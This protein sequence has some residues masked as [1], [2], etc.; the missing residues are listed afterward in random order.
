MISTKYSAPAT[1]Q[2]QSSVSSGTPP[3]T[4]LWTFPDGSTSA[5]ESPTFIFSIAGSFS[6]TFTVTDS[7]GNTST[8][9]IPITIFSSGLSVLLAV[10]PT[11]NILMYHFNTSVSGGTAPYVYLLEFGDGKHTADAT[12]NHVYAKAGTYIAK[13]TVTDS[14]GLTG[15]NTQTVNVA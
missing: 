15:S 10:S 4:Y 12:N 9:S 5:L 8:T 6:V 3:Y 11:S 7:V 13:V 14:K 1:I 2:F